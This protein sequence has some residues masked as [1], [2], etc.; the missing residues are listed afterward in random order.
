M[1]ISKNKHERIIEEIRE[2]LKLRLELLKSDT[3]IFVAKVFSDVVTNLVM[4]ICILLAFLF[5]TITLGFL[6]SDLTNSY[7]IGFSCLTVL[8]IMIALIMLSRNSF[9]E[10]LLINFSIR[11]LLDK[12]LANEKTQ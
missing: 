7:W 11:R 4:S 10:K 5:G 8:Y 3:L 12:H 1:Y 2:N 6:F 9:V